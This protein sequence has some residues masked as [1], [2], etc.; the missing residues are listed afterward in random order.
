MV[1][2]GRWFKDAVFDIVAW[3][4]ES[5]LPVLALALPDFPRYQRLAE[6]IGWLHAAARF[7]FIWVGEDGSVSLDPALQ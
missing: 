1:Q 4:D 2:A 5:P 3:R 6:R 7:V